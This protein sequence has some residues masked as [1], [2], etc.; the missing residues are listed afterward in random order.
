MHD[1]LEKLIAHEA[2]YFTMVAE[3][4]RTPYA[5]FLQG[6]DLPAYHDANRAL[7]LR[8]DG[9]GAEA[10]AREVVAFFRARGLPVVADI[11][12]VAETEGIGRALR[13]RGVTPVIG[14]TLL[15]RYPSSIPP[16]LQPSSVQVRPASPENKEETILWIETASSDTEG[17]EDAAMWRVVAALEAR[18]PACC[19]YLGWLEGRPAGTC[20]LFVAKGWG[21]IESVVTRPEFRRRGVASTL[22]AQAV[23]ESLAMGNEVT[24][25][26][27][28]A[29]GAGEAV[30]QRLGFTPWALNP[31]R[32]HIGR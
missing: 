10:V 13:Q 8:D 11:D 19:L 25:L 15:M 20:S 32:R 5:W 21:R 23:A 6:R 28:A 2:R 12:A 30:Y 17:E 22:V 16:K 9:H 31:L 24:Y 1:W 14:D 3:V 29:G 7:H 26:F 27:T 4:E 18:F